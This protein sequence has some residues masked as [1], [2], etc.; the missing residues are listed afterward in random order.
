[1]RAG[2][3]AIAYDVGVAEPLAG[4]AGNRILS[5]LSAHIPVRRRSR[6]GLRNTDVISSAV[7]RLGNAA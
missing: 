6:E 4:H 1:M 3:G 2:V 5:G 7:G